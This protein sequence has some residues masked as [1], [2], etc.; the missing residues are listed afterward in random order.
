MDVVP[1][2]CQRLCELKDD[3]CKA[4]GRKIEEI[5]RWSEMDNNEKRAVWQRLETEA[6]TL[7]NNK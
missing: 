2:P 6:N 5:S 3:V 7:P 4:C 1:S